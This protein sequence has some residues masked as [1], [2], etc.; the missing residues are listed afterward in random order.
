[1]P[2]PSSPRQATS[3]RNGWPRPVTADAVPRG[4]RWRRDAELDKEGVAAEVI[5]PDADVLGGAASAPFHAGLGS[6][7]DLDGELVMA[8]AVA[9]NRWLEELCSSSPERRCG[10][11][12][13][14]ILHDVAAAVAEIERLAAAGFRA[15]M[16]PTLWVDKPSYNDLRYEPVWSACEDNG[17]VVHVHS[18][19]ASRDIA[20]EAPGLIAIYATEAWWWAARPLW[21]LLWGG[22]FDRHP[23]LR[24]A[25]TE[26][27]AWWMPGIVQRMDEKWVGV[28]NTEKLGNAFRQTISRKPS[29]FFGTN[30]FVGASTPS[31][32]EIEQRHEI[33]VDAFMWGN[34][35][36]HPE[37]TW[38][39]TRQVD[40]GVVLRRSD[41]RGGA[42]ARAQ[43]RRG[44]RL[45]R[46]AAQRSGR[47]DRA[48]ASGRARLVD[49]RHQLM[50]TSR[51][52]RRVG[53]PPRIDR[54]AIA[55]AVLDLGLDGI[56]MKA[57]AD[58]LGRQR[59]RPVPPRA[60][61][62]GVARPGRR[63]LDRTGAGTRGPGSA[64]GR[65]AARVGP[66]RVLV[67]RRGARDPLAVPERGAPLGVHGDGHRLRRSRCSAGPAS[68]RSQRWRPSTRWRLRRRCGGPRAPPPRRGGGGALDHG[69]A[70]PH[71]RCATT[72]AL[73]GRARPAGDAPDPRGHELRGPAHDG[74]GRHRWRVG[75]ED[76]HPVAERATSGTPPQE[77]GLSRPQEDGTL[78]A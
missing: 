66:A 12:T 49:G 26:D 45:R 11:A 52:A 58:H 69:R 43:R 39:H 76:W 4:T 61:P 33:G 60:Q 25:I 1:M 21:V 10:V 15:I 17:M 78:T 41:R 68:T 73:A 34:D 8:G 18:G 3:R 72:G 14:P 65:V 16:I 36:P 37:G 19:G 29:E 31:R 28:H 35:F 23:E 24:F 67:L 62:S 74:A 20:V 13:V 55:D 75:E 77:P 54:A 56:S 71:G 2:G 30:I 51:P 59:G 44:L 57:V 5:F 22:V 9:H 53:R 47:G 48:V 7:G 40:H 46:G 42:H 27:G 32:E 38:P 50:P 64:L 6:A 70:A 63:A